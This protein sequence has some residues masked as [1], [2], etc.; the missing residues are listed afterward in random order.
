MIQFSNKK[1]FKY[2]YIQNCL[3]TS[4][5]KPVRYKKLEIYT[6]KKL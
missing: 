3:E 1:K 6:Y 5:L 4:Y 2:K